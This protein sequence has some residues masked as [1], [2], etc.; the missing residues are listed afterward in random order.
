[1]GIEILGRGIAYSLF[2]DRV[3]S[4]ELVAGIGIGGV[5][6][7][8]PSGTSSTVV[9]VYFNYYFARQQGSLYATGGATLLTE[10]VR[11]GS[12]TIGGVPVGSPVLPTAGLGYENRSDAGYLFR[13]AAYVFVGEKVVP[14]AGM[15]LGYSF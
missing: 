8:S 3:L 5:G 9:P 1:V 13:A 7:E 14:W 15:T 11:G 4:D 10:T 6:I 12:T 2:W